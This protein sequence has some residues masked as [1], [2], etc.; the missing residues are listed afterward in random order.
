MQENDIRQSTPRARVG[1]IVETAFSPGRK[2]LRGI[3]R[4][5]REH[6][7]WAIY[8]EPRGPDEFLPAMLRQWR[9]DGII[10]RVRS[11]RLGRLL[12]KSGV[13]VVDVLEGKSDHDLPPVLV[14][15]RSIAT[16]AAEHLLQRGFKQ[17]GYVGVRAVS[18]SVERRDIFVQ[19]V[20][21]SGSRC[22]VHHVMPQ[23][24]DF[25]A[26]ENE[27]NRLA[28]WVAGLPRPVGIM[29][30]D[31]LHA[32]NVL[33][34]CNRVGIMVPEEIAV[35][36]VDNDET[37]CAVC[38]P[39]LS[40]VDPGHLKVGYAAAELLD[41][42]LKGDDHPQSPLV[43]KPV[44]VMTRQSTDVLAIEDPDVA[45]AVRFIHEEV[46]RPIHVDQ[47]ADYVALSRSALQRRFQEHLGRSVYGEIMR[48]RI[49]RVCEMLAETDMS[50]GTIAKKTG[51]RH[52]A[53]MGAVF[54]EKMGFSPG[55]YRKQTAD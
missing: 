22:R 46:L 52:Q 34:A 50:I 15:N 19:A 18:W 8:H 42:L 36:G 33:A 31:D 47:V 37:V 9:C 14:D 38:D 5:A 11:K 16:L 40:T 10:A 32:Q 29:V 25:S 48:V 1:L 39:P 23:S 54:R 17:F 26:W 6:G 43:I 55:E 7:G 12:L 30:A 3:A 13:P 4:Y 24:R 51:F 35:I 21:Q 2:V 45:M 20:E 44:G 49:G 41:S 53:H 27:R 28:R